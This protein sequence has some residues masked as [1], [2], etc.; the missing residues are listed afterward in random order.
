MQQT[1]VGIIWSMRMELGRPT[2][3]V[4]GQRH[5]KKRREFG[6]G[7]H[8][9]PRE[10]EPAF[11]V[12]RRLR[13]MIPS[14]AAAAKAHQ[15]NAQRHRGSLHAPVVVWRRRA[16]ASAPVPI[17]LDQAIAQSSCKPANI[18][19]ADHRG[20]FLSGMVDPRPNPG[21]GTAAQQAP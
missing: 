14:A 2:T 10:T 9:H 5:S 18:G 13:N 11:T 12:P 6:D 20:L 17:R 19:P 7:N 15:G 16:A 1:I 3:L 4:S 8:D 21:S